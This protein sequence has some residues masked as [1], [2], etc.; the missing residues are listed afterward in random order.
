[1]ENKEIICEVADW[2]IVAKNNVSPP[3]VSPPYRG[4]GV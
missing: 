4:G 3:I 1:M 2:I